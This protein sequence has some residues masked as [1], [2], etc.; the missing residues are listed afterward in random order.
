[1]SEKKG[2]Q[3]RGNVKVRKWPTWN[4]IFS[5]ALFHYVETEKPKNAIEMT[6]LVT[7]IQA[8]STQALHRMLQ[9]E[10]PEFLEEFLP[11]DYKEERPSNIEIAR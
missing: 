7:V 2:L 3:I 11:Y 8:S 10:Y 9:E 1:M 5:W 6:G 4:Q